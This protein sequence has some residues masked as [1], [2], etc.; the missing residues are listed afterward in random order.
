MLQNYNA[1]RVAPARRLFPVPED[2]PTVKR[3]SP[4]LKLGV[5]SACVA[6]TLVPAQAAGL[7]DS[8]MGRQAAPAEPNAARGK[9]R[10]WR[11]RDFTSVQLLAHEPGAPDNQHPVKLNA[12]ALRAVLSQFKAADLRG[13]PQP[14]FA[15]DELAEITEPL[16]QAFANAEPGDDV[17]LLSSSRRDNF[18]APPTAVTA[19]LFIENGNLNFIAHDSSFEFVHIV[20]STSMSPN[21]VFGS[22][23]KA[24][25]VKLSSPAAG[26]ANRRG[27]WLT[28]ALDVARTAPAP[29][30]LPPLVGNAPPPAAA[31]TMVPSAAPQPAP[32]VA[33][34]VAAPIVK[35]VDAKADEVERRLVALKQLRDKGLI[36]EDEYKQK[37]K[38][39]LQSL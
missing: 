27:D 16:V 1:T 22:R 10:I 17:L 31:A 28:V 23:G 14:L 38:D 24:S 11:I 32:A 4:W 9:Q 3:A 26:T 36:T 13:A 5:V 2:R 29:V 19:R 35:P 34:V 7:F 18:L 6:S 12:E 21:F 39:I 33:P 37:R 15:A 30:V 8:V 25:E 20:R